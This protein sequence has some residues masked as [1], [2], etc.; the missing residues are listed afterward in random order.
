MKIPQTDP[1]AGFWAQEQEILSAVGSVFQ[2]GHYILG[3]Q[4]KAFEA[5]FASYIGVTGAVGV[6]NGTD[7][8]E[9]ALRACG[10]GAGDKVATVSHTAVATVAAIRRCGADPVFVDILP[11][12]YVMNSEALDE[13]LSSHKRGSGGPIKAVV[14]VHLY[15][16]PADMPKILK[17]ARNHGARVIEDCAQAHGASIG[18]RKVGSW[19]DLA[20]FSFYPTK[21]LGALGDGGMVVSNDS[22]LIEAVRLLRQYGWKERYVSSSEGINSRLDEVQA[23]ILNVKLVK[24]D[25]DNLARIRLAALYSKRLAGRVVCPSCP[26]E[27]VHVYHQYVV[28]VNDR[29]RICAYLADRGVGTAV[30]YPLAVHQQPAY[31]SFTRGANLHVTEAILPRILSLP[32]YPQLSSDQA[33]T[34]CDMLECAVG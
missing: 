19:G 28:E 30:H 8:I 32:M 13:V 15:G 2:G 20:A 26:P 10:V 5:A 25:D 1:L 22:G 11:S 17:V 4:V 23:A 24:L 3:P 27:C 9:L 7:A 6:A 16:C 31:E 21:N 33:N 29:D 14:P 18:G 34:V 12:T